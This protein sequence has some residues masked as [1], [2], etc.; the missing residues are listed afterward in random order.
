MANILSMKTMEGIGE[1]AGGE[2]SGWE[3]R[4]VAAKGRAR[5][6]KN[7]QN[8]CGT[9]LFAKRQG[10]YFGRGHVLHAADKS[11]QKMQK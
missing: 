9:I 2:K 5:D 11:V 3:G 1:K 10:A 6:S 7:M 8:A 4:G